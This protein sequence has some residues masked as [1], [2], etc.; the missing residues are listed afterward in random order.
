MLT[1]LSISAFE[2]TYR[3]PRPAPETILQNGSTTVLLA[4]VTSGTYFVLAVTDLQLLRWIIVIFVIFIVI[5]ARA[6]VA[7]RL[8]PRT[9]TAV[10]ST[11]GSH[12]ELVQI[13]I[14]MYLNCPSQTI[15]NKM[16]LNISA[17][18]AH[19]RSCTVK[20]KDCSKATA[21][22]TRATMQ[23]ST[24]R[25]SLTCCFKTLIETKQKRKWIVLKNTPVQMH[26]SGWR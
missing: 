7:Q 11:S 5:I 3:W 4:R 26:V 18:H 12:T 16:K 22:L 17:P 10:Q 20:T 6:N 24:K 25:G 1:K 15:E 21:F 23:P 13:E 14:L 2:N 9:S 8:R 19:T